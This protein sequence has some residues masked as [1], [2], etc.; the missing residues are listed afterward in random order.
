R[1]WAH[2][3]A[4]SP[5]K[6]P[7]NTAMVAKAAGV[8]VSTITRWAR[9]GLLPTPETKR[10]GVRGMR[11]RWPEHAPA[12]AKW[13]AGLLAQGYSYDEIRAA[14]AAGEFNPANSK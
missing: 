1:A 13:V 14:L 6:P 8:H 7:I 9:A 12:Q 2:F 4:V 3:A 5:A 10:E 11:V